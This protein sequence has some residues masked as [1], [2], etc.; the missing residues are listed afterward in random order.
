MRK[1]TFG[2]AAFMAVMLTFVVASSAMAASPISKSG[3]PDIAVELNADIAGQPVV[4]FSVTDIATDPDGDET[5]MLA[6][7]D[8]A[9]GY[10]MDSTKFTFAPS[11]WFI[12]NQEACNIQVMD[13]SEFADVYVNITIIGD[14]TNPVV[15]ITAPADNSTTQNSSVNV[16][17]SATDNDSSL[18][19]TLNDTPTVINSG[20]SVPLALGEQTIT[21]K[22]KDD[23][24]NEGSDSVTVTYDP[25]PPDEVA[26][27]VTIQSP[28]DN[29]SV[30]TDA[31]ALVYTATDDSGDVPTCNYPSGPDVPLNPGLNTITVTCT[32]DADNV[33]S[34]SVNVTYNPPPIQIYISDAQVYEPDP[35]QPAVYAKFQVSLS[36]SSTVPITLNFGTISLPPILGTATPIL[37]Y[38]LTV[39]KLVIEPGQTAGEIKVKIVA[40]TKKEANEV[41]FLLSASCDQGVEV[42][43]PVAKGTILNED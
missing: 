14:T 24:G 12:G 6:T 10:S 4:E 35:G 32:D 28:A 31:V 27:Q 22:C 40:D 3:S 21:V 8:G 33:G 9:C 18:D 11:S 17:F 16:E 13:G 5:L 37:D 36:R 25:A 43:N 30:S 42:Q 23:I 34:A 15:D 26:P 20:D 19:C 41:F 2:L 38:Q 29:A 7:A 1:H 39:G